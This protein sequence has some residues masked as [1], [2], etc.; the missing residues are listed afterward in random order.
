[1]KGLTLTTKEQTRLCI[2]NSVLGKRGSVPE[3]AQLIGVSE[4]H[5]WRLLSAYREKGAVAIAHGNRHRSPPNATPTLIKDQIISLA[6][7]CYQGCNHTHLTELL[8]EREGI[9]ASRATV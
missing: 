5:L 3:A 7:D 8:A 4:R 2:L 9:K 1:M 6:H